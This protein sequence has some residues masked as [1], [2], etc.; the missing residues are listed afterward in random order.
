METKADHCADETATMDG[1]YFLLGCVFALII[2]YTPDIL[3]PLLSHLTISLITTT[4]VPFILASHALLDELHATTLL[5]S[6]LKSIRGAYTDLNSHISSLQHSNS[7]LAQSLNTSKTRTAQLDLQVY[8]LRHCLRE[9]EFL[10]DRYDAA[11]QVQMVK[12]MSCCGETARVGVAQHDGRHGRHDSVQEPEPHSAL[13]HSYHARDRENTDFMS[14]HGA[15]FGSDRTVCLMEDT[16]TRP[17]EDVKRR[18]SATSAGSDG[19]LAVRR[20]VEGDLH[21]RFEDFVD[22][23]GVQAARIEF[24]VR[25]RVFETISHAFEICRKQGRFRPESLAGRRAPTIEDR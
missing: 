15:V 24:V 23:E 8:E 21:E 19:T 12:R 10:I 5:S 16:G 7:R 6:T 4:L 2:T 22:D 3:P 25:Q 18:L 11:A 13:L 20:M 17:S 9:A 14:R 1:P